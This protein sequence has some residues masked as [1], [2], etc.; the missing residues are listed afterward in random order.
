LEK[1]KRYIKPIVKTEERYGD[2]RIKFVKEFKKC[3]I[4][5]FESRGQKLS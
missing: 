4:D 2:Q 1:L 5:D 3:N